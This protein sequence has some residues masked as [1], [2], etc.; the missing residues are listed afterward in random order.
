MNLSEMNQKELRTEYMARRRR[1]KKLQKGQARLRKEI[2][3]V[4]PRA[5]AGD[6]ASDA[7]LLELTDLS[8]KAAT[9]MELF[10]IDAWEARRVCE[11]R[12]V[13]IPAR[14]KSE[15][16]GF[17]DADPAALEELRQRLEAESDADTAALIREG[18]V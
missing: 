3:S 7:F 2:D 5:A 13:S 18:R 14:H 12:G 4:T 10:Q 17:D 16:A 8:K 11:R 15:G 9:T 1:C 6:V